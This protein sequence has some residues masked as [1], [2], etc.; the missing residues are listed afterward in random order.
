VAGSGA[1]CLAAVRSRGIA[2]VM[3]RGIGRGPPI[4]PSGL[5]LGNTSHPP[6]ECCLVSDRTASAWRRQGLAALQCP[7]VLCDGRLAT[8]QPWVDPC[9]NAVYMSNVQGRR[10]FAPVSW[11]VTVE[12]TDSTD[13]V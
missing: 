2:D 10:P 3:G 1:F 9:R 7:D 11:T 8:V 5:G 4:A 6:V 12:V 13:S